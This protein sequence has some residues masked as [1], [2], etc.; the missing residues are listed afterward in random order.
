M[1]QK[2]VQNKISFKRFMS[3]LPNMNELQHMLDLQSEFGLVK[4]LLSESKTTTGHEQVE[5]IVRHI[6]SIRYKQKESRK[7]VHSIDESLQNST[8]SILQ[9]LQTLEFA[10][11]K[12]IHGDAMVRYKGI[13]DFKN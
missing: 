2:S 10:V 3:K 7:S 1:E 12:N 6:I 9:G 5:E 13:P 4:S 11:Q 8:S